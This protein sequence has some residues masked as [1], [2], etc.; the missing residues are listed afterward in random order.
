MTTSALMVLEAQLES[1]DAAA[2]LAAVWGAFTVATEVADA[3][4]FEEGSDEMQAL[5][6]AQQC[7][8][9]RDLLPLPQSGL[10]VEVPA[11]APGAAGLDPYVRLLEHAQKALVRLTT[12]ADRIGEGAGWSLSEATKMA[13]RAAVALGAVRER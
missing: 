12:T 8:A 7:M 11:P 10:P 4:A 9:G 1:D 3:I 5:S 2:V 6:A 13:S